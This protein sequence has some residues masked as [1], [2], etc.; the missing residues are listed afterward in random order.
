MTVEHETQTPCDDPIKVYQG[1]M[2]SDL[3]LLGDRLALLLENAEHDGVSAD[4]L[5]KLRRTSPACRKAPS[6]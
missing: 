6:P 3:D 1:A 5:I 2:Q 4:D